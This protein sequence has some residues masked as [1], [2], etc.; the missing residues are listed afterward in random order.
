MQAPRIVS[1]RLIV[2]FSALC[3]LANSSV[4]AV[5]ASAADQECTKL[6]KEILEFYRAL[7]TVFRGKPEEADRIARETQ[8]TL[9]KCQQVLKSCKETLKPGAYAEAQY[10]TAKL[11]Y[12]LSKRYRMEILNRLKEDSSLRPEALGAELKKRFNDYLSEV[13]ELAREAYKAL[14]GDHPLRPRALETLAFSLHEA[15]EYDAGEKACLDFIKRHPDDERIDEVI[16]ALGRTYLD[17]G[18]YAAGI[19]LLKSALK[20][21]YASDSYPYFVDTLRKLNVG[22]GDIA[23]FESTIKQGMLVFP[24]KLKSSR[25][26]KS[27]RDVCE[28]LFLYYGFWKGYGRM[29]AGDLPGAR[30]AF[31]DHVQLIN[32][33][34]AELRET[35]GQLRPEYAIY[36]GRSHVSLSFLDELAEQPAPRELDL[37]WVTESRVVLSDSIGKVV[38]IIFRGVDNQ[39]SREFMTEMSHVCAVNPDFELA[40]VHYLR[41]QQG[42]LLRQEELR[43]ELGS[44]GYLGAAG[45]DPDSENQSLFRAHGVK[46]GT[47]SF[48]ILDRGGNLVWFMEDPRPLDVEFV[49]S[50][51]TRVARES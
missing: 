12:I 21:Q 17:A 39:R 44:L 45:F 43:Q 8:Q 32:A 14:P 15:K 25:A 1:H 41:R 48:L 13:H 22:K 50:I 47:A 2:A 51:M 4:H 11:T 20:D 49:K 30:A 46:V 38:G 19:P 37:M 18:R 7:P 33:R 31:D 42:P 28:R 16:S 36:R 34:E 29:A 5:D 6:H 3:L 23:G 24:L 26:T 40:S 10:V 35:G 27:V 9:A